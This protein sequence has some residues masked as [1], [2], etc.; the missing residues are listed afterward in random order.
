MKKTKYSIPLAVMAGLALAAAPANAGNDQIAY[1]FRTM[2]GAT[3]GGDTLT[4]TGTHID[5]TE[6]MITAVSSTTYVYAPEDN[7]PLS[8]D[9]NLAGGAFGLSV[10]GGGG[11]SNNENLISY[12]KLVNFEDDGITPKPNV[13]AYE[14]LTISFDQDVILNVGGD[15]GSWVTTKA[16]I[17]EMISIVSSGATAATD[18]GND[19]T[20]FL[21]I[22][23]LTA[24]E[25]LTI[26]TFSTDGA[27]ATST[28]ALGALGVYTESNPVPEPATIALLALGGLVLR[29]RR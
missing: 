12:N 2:T 25:T 15:T 13:G 17:T 3:V 9:I 22:T 21:N 18:T 16:G 19:V 23:T 1:N 27:D 24:G 6:L 11:G 8:G 7:E 5:G 14:T 4:Y 29:R 10:Y 28:V 20:S 26:T